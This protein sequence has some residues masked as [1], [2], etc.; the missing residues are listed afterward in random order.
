VKYLR[1]FD[2]QGDLV[3]A[4]MSLQATRSW[5]VSVGADVLSVDNEDSVDGTFLNQFR[6]NDRYYGG[7]TYVF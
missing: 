3:G 4:E 7:L 1:E 5:A 2:Q 6:A